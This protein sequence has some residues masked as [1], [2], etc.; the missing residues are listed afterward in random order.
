MLLWFL[1]LGVLGA[2]E[3][4]RGPAVLV[5]LDP[6]YAVRF[7][8]DNPMWRSWRSAPSCWR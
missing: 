1:T 5:A 3:I 8:V 2:F 6:M 4:M 7:I